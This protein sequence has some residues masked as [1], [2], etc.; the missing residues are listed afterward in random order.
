LWTGRQL[1]NLGDC[2]IS[3]LVVIKINLSLAIAGP[4]CDLKTTIRIYSI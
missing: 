4:L 3:N 1:L 2:R